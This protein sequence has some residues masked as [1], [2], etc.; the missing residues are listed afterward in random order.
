MLQYL[1]SWHFSPRDERLTTA[2]LSHS[3]KRERDREVPAKVGWREEGKNKGKGGRDGEFH[4]NSV[5]VETAVT[6]Q[7]F[8][9]TYRLIS[10]KSCTC[11]SVCVQ[12]CERDAHMQAYV[13]VKVCGRICV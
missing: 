9:N 11:T 2:W 5:Y 12:L 10:Q 7:L 1:E 6:V 3:G 8:G 4:V 13:S